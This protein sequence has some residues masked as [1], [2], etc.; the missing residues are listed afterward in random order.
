[1]KKKKPSP[2]NKEPAESFDER[3]ARMVRS[4]Q[5]QCQREGDL[6]GRIIGF[7]EA[8]ESCMLV[9]LVD[10][11][12]HAEIFAANV[13]RYFHRHKIREY[14]SI[15]TGW[16]VK[17]EKH[18]HMRWREVEAMADQRQL[19]K[20]PD[21]RECLMIIGVRGE[22]KQAKV[23]YINRDPEERITGFEASANFE[24]PKH[25]EGRFASLLV[26]LPGH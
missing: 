18:E 22:E 3:F 6:D 7:D 23:F 19:H 14:Y 10:H 13:R 24:D 5:E 16:V 17:V 12:R 21:R 25:I 9:N 26:P 20:H 15:A 4:A 11:P 8:D 1:M 2:A